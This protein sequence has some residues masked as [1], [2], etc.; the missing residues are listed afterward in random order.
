MV[1]EKEVI[2]IVKDLSGVIASKESKNNEKI[3]LSEGSR[4][5]KFPNQSFGAAMNSSFRPKLDWFDTA[6]SS[7]LTELSFD[8]FNNDEFGATKLFWDCYGSPIVSSL[9]KNSQISGPAFVSTTSGDIEKGQTPVVWT[10][11][12]ANE[13]TGIMNSSTGKLD[14]G[15]TKKIVKGRKVVEWNVFLPGY[16]LRTNSNGEVLG[17]LELESEY[18]ALT[19]FAFNQDFTSKPF[20]KSRFAPG[21]ISAFESAL[22]TIATME[23]GRDRYALESVIMSISGEPSETAIDRLNE[24]LSNVTLLSSN[25][26]GNV[27]VD[28]SKF[29]GQSMEPVISE[30]AV[31]ASN[32]ASSMVMPVNEFGIAPA[33]GSMSAQSMDKTSKPFK[34]LVT[35]SREAYGRSIKEMTVIGLELMLG[36]KEAEFNQIQPIWKENLDTSNMGELG[37]LIVQ[38]AGVYPEISDTD[39]IRKHL[40]ISKRDEL[41][42]IN[43]VD[44]RNRDEINKAREALQSGAVG[45]EG[46]FDLT[47]KNADIEGE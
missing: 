12:S 27:D 20:G 16:I 29:G 24:A 9:M 34:N 28:I 19:L 11:F 47:T 1:N 44:N 17:E 18:T 5:V 35:R 38:I 26:G 25:T 10:P 32:F 46:F 15:L 8:A 37:N 30:F 22:R 14:Y 41:L 3:K 31:H 2:S 43:Y 6:V 13:A 45:E 33:N 4:D 39:F 36:E 40:G 7:L 23:E 21:A 42:K